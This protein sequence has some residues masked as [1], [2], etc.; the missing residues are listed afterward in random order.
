MKANED[1]QDFF[2]ARV[3]MKYSSKI[4]RE[5]Q[6]QSSGSRLRSPRREL[7]SVQKFIRSDPLW[8]ALSFWQELFYGDMVRIVASPFLSSCALSF[9]PSATEQKACKEIRQI[10]R[11]VN[12]VVYGSREKICHEIH[13][14]LYENHGCRVGASA[15]AAREFCV[16]YFREPGPFVGRAGEGAR[17]F[18]ILFYF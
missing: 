2:A 8:R 18:S 9:N 15:N 12:I 16:L 6:M 17:T 4:V 7:E 1:N 11:L 13:R 10:A 14:G 5:V 3:L